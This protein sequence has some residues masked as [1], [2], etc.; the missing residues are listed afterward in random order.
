MREEHL[1]GLELRLLSP[2]QVEPSLDHSVTTGFAAMEDGSDLR[3]A[4]PDL[5][6]GTEDAK[7]LKVLFAVVAVA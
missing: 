7:A 2:N 4:Q 1:R 6:T 5:L 3:E